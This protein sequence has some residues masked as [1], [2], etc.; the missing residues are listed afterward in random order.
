[1]YYIAGG[2]FVVSFAL[3]YLYDSPIIMIFGIGFSMITYG[4][5][6]YLDGKK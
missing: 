1:M 4:F 3:S 6:N 5:F 2:I